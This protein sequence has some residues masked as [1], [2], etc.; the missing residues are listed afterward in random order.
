MSTC[1]PCPPCEI[2]NPLV[3]EPHGVVSTG[4]RVLVEDDAFCTKTLANPNENAQLVWENGVK[5]K[6]GFGWKSISSLYYAQNFDKLSVNSA[7]GAILIYLPQNPSQF[8]EIVFADQ[9]GSWG[10]NNVTLL[11]NGSLIE[12]LAEDLVLDTTWPTQIILRFEGSTW[13][14]Y[15]IL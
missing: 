1:I 4:N 3:C 2:E 14:V 15:A 9:S 7:A 10:T 12:G 11:R 8:D 13:R 6:T 5:W